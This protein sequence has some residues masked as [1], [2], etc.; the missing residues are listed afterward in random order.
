MFASIKSFSKENSILESQTRNRN[1]QKPVFN[2]VRMS[3]IATLPSTRPEKK[4][5]DTKQRQQF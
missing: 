4:L 3:S 2:I 5:Q 1:S